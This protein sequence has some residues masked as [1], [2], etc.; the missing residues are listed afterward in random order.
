VC[1]CYISICRANQLTNEQTSV[2][3]GTKTYAFYTRPG[4][5][6]V[7]ET[8]PGVERSL[9]S[10][11]GKLG[12]LCVCVRERERERESRERIFV[13]DGGEKIRDVKFFSPPGG[14]KRSGRSFSEITPPRG[15]GHFFLFSRNQVTS[16]NLGESGFLSHFRPW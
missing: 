6:P 2:V 16:S 14:L 13:N 15:V 1:V 5:G 10:I 9:T 7:K 8:P 3:V 4:K 11:P 12:R